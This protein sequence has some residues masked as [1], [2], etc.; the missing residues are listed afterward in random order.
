MAPNRGFLIFC[1]FR[2]TAICHPTHWFFKLYQ[3]HCASWDDVHHCGVFFHG[4][5]ANCM[6]VGFY[7]TETARMKEFLIT[8]RHTNINDNGHWSEQLTDVWCFDMMSPSPL[9]RLVFASHGMRSLLKTFTFLF[10][11][12]CHFLNLSLKKQQKKTPIS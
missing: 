3:Y 5:G 4:E 2:Y 8:H 1:T 10:W 6:C 12:N 7:E 9:R 11:V